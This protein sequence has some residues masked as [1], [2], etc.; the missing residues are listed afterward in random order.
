M[1]AN[2]QNMFVAGIEQY[3][4]SLYARALSRLCGVEMQKPG[5]LYKALNA[6]TLRP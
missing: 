3:I 5:D 6:C 4:K 2:T 1:I